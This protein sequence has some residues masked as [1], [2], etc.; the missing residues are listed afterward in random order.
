[1][2]Q[3]FERGDFYLGFDCSSPDEQNCWL[4]AGIPG[5][6]TT[7]AHMGAD[8]LSRCWQGVQCTTEA[9]TVEEVTAASRR[10]GHV[11]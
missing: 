7:S 10:Y 11:W 9:L 3:N 8:L 2:K 6:T 4:T 5:T 1:M